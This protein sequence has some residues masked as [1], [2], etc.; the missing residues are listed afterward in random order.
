MAK[1]GKKWH[2]FTSEFLEK[3]RIRQGHLEDQNYV[4]KPFEGDCFGKSNFL[5]G[6]DC[7]RKVSHRAGWSTS[8]RALRSS[9]YNLTIWIPK[10]LLKLYFTIY[11]D[12]N[13]IT[14]AIYR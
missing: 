5:I 10:K 11:S 14:D 4:E 9:L 13:E 8:Y 2:F 7:T 1:S 12:V 6:F 3:L